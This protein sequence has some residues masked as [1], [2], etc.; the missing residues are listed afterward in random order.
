MAEI[1]LDLSVYREETADIRM[2]NGVV[3]HLNKPTEALVI[4]LL[5]LRNVDA[6]AASVE[7]LDALNRVCRAVLN[8]N[9]DGVEFGPEV[10]AALPMDQKAAII[11]AYTDFATR[12]QANPIYSSPSSPETKPETEEKSSSRGWFGRWRSTRG[13]ASG[14]R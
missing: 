5:Q 1:I 6:T 10:V 7:L 9:A 8:N 11:S 14:R 4:E 3:V 13:K 2:S 12:L